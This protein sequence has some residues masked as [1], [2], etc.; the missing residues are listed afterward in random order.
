[1]KYLKKYKIVV[2]ILVILVLIFVLGMIFSKKNMDNDNEMSG[3][4][5]IDKNNKENVKIKDNVKYNISKEINKDQYL[6]NPLDKS[7]NNKLVLKDVKI[8]GDMERDICHFSGVLY[9]NT[10]VS[11]EKLFTTT[12]FYDSDGNYMSGFERICEDLEA[13]G[14]CDMDFDIGIDISNAYSMEMLYSVME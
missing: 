14:S 8:E 13:G 2:I 10:T 4:Y 7:S 3:Q 11:F 9:N 12:S 1:M 6:I 5:V